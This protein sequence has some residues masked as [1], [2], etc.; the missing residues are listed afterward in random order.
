MLQF[1]NSLSSGKDSNNNIVGEPT[2]KTYLATSPEA[3]TTLKSQMFSLFDGNDELC[4]S[5]ERFLQKR[6][7]Y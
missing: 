4:A 1:H 6:T 7:K 3:V 5:F 2:A